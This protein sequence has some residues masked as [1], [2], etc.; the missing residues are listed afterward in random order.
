MNAEFSAGCLFISW[1]TVPPDELLDAVGFYFRTDPANK[2]RQEFYKCFPHTLGFYYGT[3]L[4]RPSG[5][6][7]DAFGMPNSTLATLF[8]LIGI[9]FWFL[10]LLAAGFAVWVWRRTRP[11]P[12]PAT[13]FPVEIA[14][15]KERA[16]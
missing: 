8:R 6:S 1:R 15:G 10:T 12:N 11:K 16:K 4:F 13:A 5:P 2:G 14:D 7:T 3:E 9:P